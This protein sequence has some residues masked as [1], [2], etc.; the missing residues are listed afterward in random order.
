MTQDG[1]AGCAY[2]YIGG[3]D[4]TEPMDQQTMPSEAQMA[5]QAHV[6][7]SPQRPAS[8][9]ANVYTYRVGGLVTTT[10]TV[11]VRVQVDVV[12]R[13]QPGVVLDTRATA[14]EQL[15]TVRLVAPRSAK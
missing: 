11:Q 1:L 6:Y 13:E 12:S 2:A 9:R 5:S 15:Y 10:M 4:A 7:W 14:H 3:E 8:M